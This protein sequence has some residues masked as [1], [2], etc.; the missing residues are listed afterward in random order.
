M[1]YGAVTPYMIVVAD[2]KEQLFN[3]S[4]I[5]TAVTEAVFGDEQIVFAGDTFEH[6]YSKNGIWNGPSGPRNKHVSA[7]LLLPKTG[8]WK[9]REENWQP[10]MAVNPW[11]T[12]PIANSIKQLKRL[13]AID[14]RWVLRGG[15]LFA[16]I[17]GLPTPWPPVD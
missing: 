14:G 8:I 13:E 3:E 5:K 7:V 9:L 2:A 4:H 12:F 15:P 17:L 16:D 6:D 1:G 11:A 10:I